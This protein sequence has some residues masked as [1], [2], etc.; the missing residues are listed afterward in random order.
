[1][2]WQDR[3]KEAAYISPLGFRTIFDYEDVSKKIDKKT[4]DFEF[5]AANGTYMQDLG[6]SGYRYPVRTFFYGDNYDKEA[7]AFE[8]QL[9]ERG[10]G[11][12][13]HP[14]YGTINVVPSGT[15]TRRDDLKTATNQAVI[16]VTLWQT[17]F[18]L[19]AGAIT[20]LADAVFGAI[21]FYNEAASGQLNTEIILDKVFETTAFKQF[22]GRLIGGATDALKGIAGAEPNIATQFRQVGNSMQ[23]DLSSE[24]DPN[25]PVLASQTTTFLQ[26]PA[27]ASTVN[28]D[29]RM[30][31][32]NDLLAPIIDPVNIVESSY[33]Q[34]QDNEFH[35]RDMHAATYISGMIVSAVNTVFD[36][37]PAA[38]NAADQIATAFEAWTTWRETNYLKLEKNDIGELYRGLQES[39]ALTVGYLIEISFTL[40]TEK[41]ITLTRNRS[42]IDLVA[43]LYGTIDDKLDFFINTNNLTG[44]EILELPKGR[45]VV[46]YI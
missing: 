36:I 33:D 41:I 22:Y 21:T 34:R 20:D 12:L 43:E 32:Y 29:A 14:I 4:T 6:R 23:A 46:Y 28:I 9:L 26:L 10:V 44:S 16:E 45:Q 25:V 37:K 13:E 30:N 35:T 1:M 19:Y 38:L 24:N 39:V 2:A 42:I 18:E 15:I 5:P 31:A 11:R 7:L 8:A 40:Q 27:K 17:I 3:I